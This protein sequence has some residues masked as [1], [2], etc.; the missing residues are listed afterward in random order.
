MYIKPYSC[1]SLVFILF[2]V[3][4]YSSRRGSVQGP[5]SYFFSILNIH[6]RKD[7]HF[8]YLTLKNAISLTYLP[9]KN[10][11]LKQEL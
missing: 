8:V 7:T 6:G 1:L 11:W 9:D 4:L 2:Y 10:K 5:T 3:S